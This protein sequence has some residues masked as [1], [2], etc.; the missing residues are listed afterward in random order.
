MVHL[1]ADRKWI[2][3]KQNAWRVFIFLKMGTSG[4]LLL[5][6]NEPWVP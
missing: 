4:G 6:H 3:K 5:T 1:I 2:M